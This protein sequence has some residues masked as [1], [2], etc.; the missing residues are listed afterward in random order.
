MFYLFKVKS[1]EML[2]VGTKIPEQDLLVETP[3]STH[4]ILPIASGALPVAI[5]LAG[6]CWTPELQRIPLIFTCYVPERSSPP[7]IRM[8]FSLPIGYAE[9]EP[10][11]DDKSEQVKTLI[12]LAKE[13][14]KDDFKDL[15]RAV[16]VPE[17]HLEE[18]WQGTRSK[19]HKEA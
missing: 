4:R 11:Q 18:L 6:W 10:S 3:D 13:G 2:P 1:D 19:L 16:G 5:W 17:H 15:G 12:A 7:N 9:D 14:K 8:L